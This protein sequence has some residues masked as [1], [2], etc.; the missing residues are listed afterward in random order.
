[1]TLLCATNRRKFVVLR[2]FQANRGTRGGDRWPVQNR[3]E[4]RQPDFVAACLRVRPQSELTRRHAATKGYVAQPV[5]IVPLAPRIQQHIDLGCG[6]RPR[7]ALGVFV[8][9]LPSVL[10]AG[11]WGPTGETGDRGDTCH[12]DGSPP[13]A[14]TSVRNAPMRSR[15]SSTCSSIVF[16][17][18]CSCF[19][20][21]SAP[22]LIVVA[23]F[24]I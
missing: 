9:R 6:Q 4:L 14:P 2:K 5:E 22:F 12:A 19:R 10:T 23:D 20:I 13:P 1:V 21:V 24:W 8:V 16:R 3:C 18:F 15:N 11:T 17:S 7:C